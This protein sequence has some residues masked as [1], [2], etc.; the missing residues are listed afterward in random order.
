MRILFLCN[1]F[2][3][4]SVACLE[5][6]HAARR[7]EISVGM[8]RRPG[9]NIRSLAVQMFRRYGVGEGLRRGQQFVWSKARVQ[10]RRIG[11]RFSGYGTIR[12][13]LEVYNLDL[14]HFENFNHPSAVRVLGEREFDLFIAGAFPQILGP[15]LLAVPR[16]G[17]LNVHLSLLPKYRG[18]SPCH[19]ALE[20][21]EHTTGV[22]VHYMDLG[23]DSGD[24]VLQRV[25]PIDPGESPQKLERRLAPIGAELLLEAIAQIEAGTACR[26]PQRHADAN[27]YS[28][29]RSR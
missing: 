22:T 24:I 21:G 29:P 8:L 23:I 9:D 10:G 15:E 20:N 17:A 5:S 1:N 26:A 12:E 3:P 18:P 11:M 14:W 19:W 2:H 27:Y 7:F 13:F 25:V 6:L 4:L 28:F 16:L